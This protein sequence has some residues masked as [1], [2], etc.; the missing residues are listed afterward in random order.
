[1]ESTVPVGARRNAGKGC[2]HWRRWSY[3]VLAWVPAALGAVAADLANGLAETA[4]GARTML[5]MHR[6]R[7]SE[8][9]GARWDNFFEAYTGRHAVDA[10]AAQNGSRAVRFAV[11][12]PNPSSGFAD[13]LVGLTS[14]FIFSLVSQRDLLIDWP[15][16]FSVFDLPGGSGAG[17][18]YDAGAHANRTVRRHDSLGCETLRACFDGRG[19]QA[20]EEDVAVFNINRGPFHLL[21]GEDGG[22]PD[23]RQLYTSKLLQA[24]PERSF[25]QNHGFTC[26]LRS[27][28]V[29]KQSLVAANYRMAE[30]VAHPSMF[31]VLWHVR[32]GD[33]AFLPGHNYLRHLNNLRRHFSLAAKTACAGAS[34]GSPP[35]V[36]VLSDSFDFARFVKRHWLLPCEAGLVVVPDRPPLHVSTAP[37][38]EVALARAAGDWWLA[39]LCSAFVL[40]GSPEQSGF[41]NTAFGYAGRAGYVLDGSGYVDVLHSY[42][43]IASNWSGL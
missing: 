13:R 17:Y 40:S 42:W 6:Q 9:C 1:M 30:A 27:L 32:F 15:E 20:F 19:P 23:L 21:F 8:I 22:E 12:T 11:F 43:P 25:W 34:P 39:T 29:P 4:T 24:I 38:P 31:S 26:T 33:A 5:E 10:L 36:F 3:A 7:T 41:R 35:R 28:L 2:S 18:L 16:L 37:T 14:V